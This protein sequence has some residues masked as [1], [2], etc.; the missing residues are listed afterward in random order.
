MSIGTPA[1]NLACGHLTQSHYKTFPGDCSRCPQEN[2]N[3]FY[4]IHGIIADYFKDKSKQRLRN[5]PDFIRYD[6]DEWC[7]LIKEFLYYSCF[8]QPENDYTSELVCHLFAASYLRKEKFIKELFF[9]ILYK[10]FS[11][12]NHPLL[13]SRTQIILKKLSFIVRYGWV[14]FELDHTTDYGKY[15]HEIEQASQLCKNSLGQI[16]DGIGKIAILEFIIK[17]C[18]TGIS[19]NSELTKV[20]EKQLHDQLEK[21]DDN[22]DPI[23][24]SRLFL[25]TVCWKTSSDD[26]ELINLCNKLLK[27]R[28]SNASAYF[29]KGEIF[30][31]RAQHFCGLA[32]S[33]SLTENLEEAILLFE[34]AIKIQPYDHRF[35][36]ARGHAWFKRATSFEEEKDIQENDLKSKIID[37]PDSSKLELGDILWQSM[38]YQKAVESYDKTLQYYDDDILR[39]KKTESDSKSE[40]LLEIYLL[41]KYGGKRR[42]ESIDS[43]GDRKKQSDKED[44]T[45]VQLT[46]DGDCLRKKAY[47]IAQEK[48]KVSKLKEAIS[49][50]EKAIYKNPEHPLGWYGRG[51]CYL[52]IGKTYEDLREESSFK[53]AIDDFQK[54]LVLNE[55]LSWAH[56]D[57]GITYFELSIRETRR[58]FWDSECEQDMSINDLNGNELLK[59]NTISGNTSHLTKI[60]NEKLQKALHDFD[61]AIRINPEYERAWYY[62]GLVLAKLGRHEEA[63]ASYDRSIQITK[64]IQETMTKER[65]FSYFDRG[66]SYVF[67][68]KYEEAI[69]SFK[70]SCKQTESRNQQNQ[71][72]IQS[73]NSLR[74]KYYETLAVLVKSDLSEIEE[75]DNILSGLKTSI[76][77]KEIETYKIGLISI[78]TNLY[79]FCLKLE[80]PNNRQDQ[81]NQDSYDIKSIWNSNYEEC[82]IY[83]FKKILDQLV[84]DSK[85]RSF[86]DSLVCCLIEFGEAICRQLNDNLDNSEDSKKDSEQKKYEE[87]SIVLFRLWPQVQ[88]FYQANTR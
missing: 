88:R 12:D 16:E 10:E 31:D 29:H 66:V 68:N 73:L 83:L 62:R 39:Q 60:I 56:Y 9:D 38:C 76:E 51:L 64:I 50:Y 18:H 25:Q 13:H 27:H 1:A 47:D 85:I 81:S 42:L 71:K 59:G 23:F 84:G 63:I 19:Y 65:G 67:E 2:R 57:R 77:N 87:S 4:K 53:K 43:Q 40:N 41:R 20:Y 55:D 78:A 48:E 8:I 34:R 35:W 36:E 14:A 58:G 17:N 44:R 32:K 49:C 30:L 52:E 72:G 61:D 79:I 33:K 26:E 75:T 6:D 28:S 69:S 11:P 45:H 24:Y 54:A 7:E 22:Y 82:D 21:L 74:A 37:Y 3:K 15:S 46:K 70:K 86:S 5:G 80:S